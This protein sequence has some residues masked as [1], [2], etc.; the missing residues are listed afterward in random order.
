[1][2]AI[3]N[4]IEEKP[5][6]EIVD[7]RAIFP[8]DLFFPEGSFRDKTEAMEYMTEIMKKKD[9]ITESVKQSIFKREEMATTELEVWWQF[10]M[11]CLITPRKRLCR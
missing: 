7:Y 6:G 4:A 8:K 1:M 11:R 2:R 5:N 3:Q 9:Y 10:R